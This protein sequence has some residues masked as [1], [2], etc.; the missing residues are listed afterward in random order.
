MLY[1]KKFVFSFFFLLSFLFAKNV[2]AE[3]MYLYDVSYD[4]N[5]KSIT[6]KT[7]RGVKSDSI[8]VDNP[9]R[10]VI[11][12]ESTIFS[13]VSKKIDVNDGYIKQIRVAQFQADPPIS[14]ISIDTD[15]HIDFETR[16]EEN[17]NGMNIVYTP[18]EFLKSNISIN[19]NLVK[20]Y[21][22]KRRIINDVEALEYSG[23]KLIIS[24]KSKINYKIEKLD[25]STYSVKL[26][27]FTMSGI[28]EIPVKINHDI[29]DIKIK[30]KDNNSEFIFKVK[31]N[32][33]LAAK[34]NESNKIEFYT[35]NLVDSNPINYSNTPAVNDLNTTNTNNNF[36]SLDFLEKD[37][38]SKVYISTSTKSLNYKLFK[39]SNP[40]R[41]VIDTFGTNVKDFI[42]P[43][44]DK[45][46][47]NILR[48]RIGLIEKTATQPEGVRIVFEMKTRV[49][50]E[51]KLQNDKTL[52]I[53]FK[54]LN[55]DYYS[56]QKP[57]FASNVKKR[58]V[59]ALDPGHG[60]N[61][62]GAVG[63]AGYREKDVTLAVTYYLRQMLLDN[64]LAVLMARSD[65][66]EIL[67]QPRVDVA[68]NN[69][70]DLFVSIH[71][72]SMDGD[73]AKGFETYYRTPQSVAFAQ[74]MHKN[75][76]DNLGVIDRGIRVRNFFVI[77]KTTMPSLLLEIG[78]ISNPSE[79]QSL[80]SVSYQ[81]RVAAS[82][83]KGIK[84]YL[85]TQG[86]I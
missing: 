37:I 60:G 38:N 14:R 29:K 74:V 15:K 62:P 71:C 26:N 68:N 35:D 47:K 50:V 56:Q 40:D 52:E 43:L 42:D 30:E 77:R 65:D 23:N 17:R 57:I 10:T 83:Y 66:S 55:N 33:K 27:D 70:A 46:S 64:G 21:A 39:L 53:T 28:N 16:I 59:I 86:K 13:S 36:V 75:I 4:S 25:N 18:T 1:K 44:L 2:Y 48:S 9:P 82:I 84:E 41:L 3:N 79:E 34:L 12:L 19:N 6:L 78:Y 73:T 80:A 32:V 5:T 67:L 72:N 31:P 22:E 20:K 7:S 51:E 76:I 45:Y 8:K 69:G 81:K 24:A 61:D 49:E 54:G 63:K 85:G 58:F 11:N